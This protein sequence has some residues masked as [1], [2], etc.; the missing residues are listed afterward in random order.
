MSDMTNKWCWWRADEERF[1]MTD[2]EG[3]AHG[4]AQCSIDC[5]GEEGDAYTY[6]VAR[7]AHPMDYVGLEWIA[8]HIASDIEENI[9]CWCDDNTG[10]EDA[11][12]ELHPEDRE[13]L[14][15]MV[16]AFV[17]EK[18]ITNWWTAAKGTEVEHTY[19]AGSNDKEGGAT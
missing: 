12:I 15:K 4:E 1:R 17:R 10:A 7:V 3:E 11:S 13:A 5:D 14:G 19:V 18:A 16:A 6:T 9:C 2:T 8:S